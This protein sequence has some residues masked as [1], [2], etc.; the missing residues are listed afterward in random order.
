[1]ARGVHTHIQRE[2]FAHRMSDLDAKEGFQTQK[3][4]FKGSKTGKGFRC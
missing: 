2:G 3:E 1:M 4:G